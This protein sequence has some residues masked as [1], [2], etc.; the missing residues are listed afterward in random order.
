MRKRLLTR[1]AAAGAGGA[2]AFAVA[3]P[4]LADDTEETA[5]ITD[6]PDR[7]DHVEDGLLE[8]ATALDNLDDRCGEGFNVKRDAET[9]S[10]T[11]GEVTVT[12]TAG[13]AD[14]HYTISITDDIEGADAKITEAHIFGASLYRSYLFE[15][16]VFEAENVRAP[17]P[18][19]QEEAPA[20]I[21]HTIFCWELQEENGEDG[22]EENGKEDEEDPD[23]LPVTGAQVGGLLVLAI[24]LLAAGGAML[25]VRRRR[26][27]AN[28]LES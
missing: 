26:N 12:V 23:E 25:F 5:V 18:R 14:H 21:S 1:I 9:G 27:L 3:A 11:L 20:D 2:L 15:P 28:L 17:F 8:S 24:G 22:E 10:E 4:G 6:P 7:L 16:G 13:P 19:G